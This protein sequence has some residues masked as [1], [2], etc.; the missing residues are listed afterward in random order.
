MASQQNAAQIKMESVIS[1]I[2]MELEDRKT[3]RKRREEAPSK[4][5]V[6]LQASQG[7]GD[8]TS[9]RPLMQSFCF[10]ASGGGG[11]LIAGV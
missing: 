3:K 1:G 10:F 8:A 9:F 7:L 6:K 5:E 11:C 4:E 2:R